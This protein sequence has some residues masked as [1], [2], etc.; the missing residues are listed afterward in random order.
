MKS[1]YQ[2]GVNGPKANGTN[3]Q[4][5]GQKM[6]PLYLAAATIVNVFYIFKYSFRE[7]PLWPSG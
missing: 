5:F 7:F 2:Q 1:H 3:F 4:R 6:N